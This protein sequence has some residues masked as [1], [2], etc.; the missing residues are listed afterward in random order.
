MQ[1]AIVYNTYSAKGKGI[2]IAKIVAEMCES[3]KIITQLFENDWPA[4]FD[5]FQFVFLIG[6]DGTINYF[7]N[8]YPNLQTPLAI[9][10]GGTGNDLFWKIYGMK[11]TTQ[12]IEKVCT[13]LQKNGLHTCIKIVDIG[14]CELQS[15]PNEVV[16]TKYFINGIGLG[17]DGEVLKNMDT[18]RW[19]FWY[20][21]F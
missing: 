21:W 19:I 15:E 4:N 20:K 17:F 6:G 16:S 3:F 9:L 11:T 5:I 18:I 1:I 13:L 2:A 12:I 7:I 8:Q 14:E 10:P